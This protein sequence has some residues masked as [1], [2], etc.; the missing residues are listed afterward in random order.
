MLV[1]EVGLLLTGD[2]DTQRW[3]TAYVWVAGVSSMLLNAWAFAQHAQ[4][5]MQWT[6]LPL[7]ILVPFLV[8]VLGKIGGKLWLE[9]SAK[10]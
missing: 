6:A 8:L 5:G 2:R 3:A 10:K 1:S 7:G 4:E 9:G